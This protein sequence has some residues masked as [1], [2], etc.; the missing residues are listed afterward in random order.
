M[1]QHYE[2]IICLCCFLIYFTNIGMPSTSFNVFQP[3]IAGLDFTGNTGASTILATRTFTSLVCMFFVGRYVE[4]LGARKGAALAASLT[5]LGFFLFSFATSM[6]GFLAGAVAA[7]AGYGLGGVV[8]V[9]LVTR[10]WFATGVGKAMGIATMGSGVSSMVLSPLVAY[11]IENSSLNWGFRFEAFIALACAAFVFAFFR[12][13][14]S[15]LGR[16][17]YEAPEKPERVNKS[18][19]AARTEPLPKP[20]MALFTFG[21]VCTAGMCVDAYNYFSILFTSEGISTMHAATLLAILGAALT[22]AK[23]ASGVIMDFMGTLRSTVLMFALSAAGLAFACFC[24]SNDVFPYL[25]VLLFGCGVTL[26]SVGIS[27][28]SMELATPETMTKTVKNLQIAY[29]LGGFI[30]SVVPGPLA[31]FTGSYVS[32]YVIFLALA[33]IGGTVIIGIYRRYAG[34]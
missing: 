5:S 23:F 12:G 34:N 8:I 4:L 7:G 1:K 21:V 24:G 17:P 20:I 13:D 29:A 22:A 2:K 6:P 10:R 3:Y 19:H 32:S 28:W 31:D 11:I 30:F 25:A 18:R 14:P 26:G 33:V 9:T 16:K 27:M 15:S